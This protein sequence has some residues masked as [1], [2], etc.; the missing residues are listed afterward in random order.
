LTNQATQAA[1]VPLAVIAATAVPL[2]ATAATVVPLAATA[3]T[4]VFFK[5]IPLKSLL[6]HSR[7]RLEGAGLEDFSRER[8]YFL[9][10]KTVL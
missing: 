3:A 1:A 2:A 8:S 5:K 7:S 4:A 10:F 6:F 9:R